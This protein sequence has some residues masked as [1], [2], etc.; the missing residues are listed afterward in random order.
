MGNYYIY[1]IVISYFSIKPRAF[2][3]GN[4]IQTQKYKMNLIVDFMN[5]NSTLNMEK[6]KNN[7]EQHS[8]IPSI[9]LSTHTLHLLCCLFIYFTY[10]GYVQYLHT[11]LYLRDFNPMLFISS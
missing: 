9:D 8:P 10:G 6:Y 7:G 4:I 5:S 2:R 3:E 11:Y 1:N